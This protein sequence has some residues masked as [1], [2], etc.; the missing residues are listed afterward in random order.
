[1][2]EYERIADPQVFGAKYFFA[3]FCFKIKM[4]EPDGCR[5]GGFYREVEMLV[6]HQSA[7]TLDGKFIIIER[8]QIG[9]VEAVR[10][11]F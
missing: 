2:G 5:V 8:I 1:M 10:Q 4:V 6:F 3:V 11:G 7:D 9:A